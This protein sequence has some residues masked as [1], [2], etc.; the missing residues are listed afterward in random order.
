MQSIFP[1]PQ[2]FS[3]YKTLCKIWQNTYKFHLYCWDHV[4]KVNE[5]CLVDYFHCKSRISTQIMVPNY[6]ITKCKEFSTCSKL[7]MTLPAIFFTIQIISV[8][9]NSDKILDF[10]WYKSSLKA[11]FQSDTISDSAPKHMFPWTI[12]SLNSLPFLLDKLVP[13]KTIQFRIEGHF[14]VP[15]KTWGELDRKQH[16]HLFQRQLIVLEVNLV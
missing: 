13:D 12:L 5:W 15:F 10:P 14:P 6:C 11:P 4:C 1:L 8:S 16:R 3:Q 7:L 9:S 2:L